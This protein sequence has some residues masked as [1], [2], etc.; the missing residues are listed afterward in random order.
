MGLNDGP[1]RLLLV[2]NET[3]LP[4]VHQRA[5]R[6]LPL[7]VNGLRVRGCEVS[8]ALLRGEEVVTA[9]LER[10]QIPA[11]RLGFRHY[12]DGPTAVARLVRVLNETPL[13]VVSGRE[14]IPAIL[15]GTAGAFARSPAQI[16]YFRAHTYG[17]FK[18][19]SASRV[20]SGLCHHTVAISRAVARCAR[21]FDRADPE[22]IHTAYFG[23]EDVR[24][25]RSEELVRLR[26]RLGIDP[27]SSVVVIVARMRHEKGVDVGILA[28]RYVA[29]LLGRPP[30]VIVVGSGPEDSNLRA[31]ASEHRSVRVHFVGYQQDVAPWLA[32]G[33]VV[34]VPSRKEACGLTTVE[35]MAS[36]RPV[37]ATNVGGLPEL[38]EDG[39]TGFLAPPERPEAIAERCAFLLSDPK[40]RS[41]MGRAARA[42]YEGLFSLDVMLDRWVELWHQEVSASIN[43]T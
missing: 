39:I 41:H 11:A 3:P 6:R 37:V 1:L 5:A 10:D 16:E 8:V 17:G 28:M 32:L 14:V 15:S 30:E 2:T 31:V 9:A 19:N 42:R 12:W 24:E 29:R 18:L 20:A 36:A 22:R 23:K 40:L 13:D 34:V 35:A 27:T 26:F 4:E 25:V 38:V 43:L 33:D 21:E 7:L